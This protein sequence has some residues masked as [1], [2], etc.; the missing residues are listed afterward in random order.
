MTGTPTPV[1]AAWRIDAATGADLE[2]LAD[3]ESTAFPHPWNHALLADELAHPH[4]ILLTAREDPEA[5]PAA[6]A[7]FRM[8]AGE[9]ELLRIATV[10][11]ARGRGA[12][13]ALLEA[14][15]ARLAAAGC[16]RCHLEVRTDNAAAIALYQRRGF[17]R[18][19]YRRGYYA[20]GGDAVLFALELGGER[21][22]R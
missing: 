8:L 4:A 5:A 3:L 14:G 22:A 10:P 19:G 11:A 7:A 16:A 18:R 17:T 6:Y 2:A 21:D 9:G 1:P 20:D 12:A 13:R 15:L